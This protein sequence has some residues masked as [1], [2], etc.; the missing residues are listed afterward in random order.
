M[1][2]LWFLCG[3]NYV[4]VGYV[5]VN[6]GYYFLEDFVRDGI[7]KVFGIYVIGWVDVGNVYG[8]WFYVINGF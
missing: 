2:F 7:F 1:G 3:N 6:N 8:M 4:C 5:D